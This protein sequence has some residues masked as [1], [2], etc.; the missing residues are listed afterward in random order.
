MGENIKLSRCFVMS[1]SSHG[2]V[3]AY[4]HRSPQPGLFFVLLSYCFIDNMHHMHACFPRQTLNAFS[5]HIL[6]DYLSCNLNALGK[7]GFDTT[8]DIITILSGCRFGSNC[9]NFIS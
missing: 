9:W 3:S 5:P 4:L 1:T 6:T 7:R 8:K 2:V